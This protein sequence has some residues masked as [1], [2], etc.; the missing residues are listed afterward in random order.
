MYQ[1]DFTPQIQ[2]HPAYPQSSSNRRLEDDDHVF[3]TLGT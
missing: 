3:A 2:S 1:D